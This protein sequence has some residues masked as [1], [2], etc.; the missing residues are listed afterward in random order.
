MT[1]VRGEVAPNAVVSGHDCTV[2]GTRFQLK[3]AG[4][5]TDPEWR[6]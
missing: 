2:V 1:V 4:N 6:R 3:E 5:T